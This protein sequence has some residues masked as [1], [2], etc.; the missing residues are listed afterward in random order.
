MT[1]ITSMYE[2]GFLQ[3]KQIENN[4]LFHITTPCIIR[5]ESDIVQSLKKNYIATEEIGGVL[6]AKPTLINNERFF[7]IESVSYVRNAIEDNHRTDG[8]NKT[9]AYCPDKTEINNALTSIIKNNCLP[10][11]FH[12]HPT[13][14][15]EYFESEI[16][17]IYQTDTSEQDKKESEYFFNIGEAKLLMPRCL[18]VGNAGLSSDIF[19]GIYGGFITPV[20]FEESKK[21]VVDEK[22]RKTAD[23]LS[24]I[25]L[26]K[27]QKIGLGIGAALALFAI[28]KYP[29]YSLPVIAGLS[30]ASYATLTNTKTVA[31]PEYYNKL[32]SGS[33]TIYIP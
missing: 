1:L 22:I 18:I 6:S 27:G 4:E 16:N 12:T 30:I 3:T 32:S 10:I 24:E 26:T 9:N 14:G 33:A 21:K 31:K 11:K 5:I 15:K 28:I 13:K 8:R 17:Q 7:I 23:F 25:D 2:F 20:G 19:I 29:K